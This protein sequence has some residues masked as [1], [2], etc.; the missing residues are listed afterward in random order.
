MNW[1]IGVDV[2]DRLSYKCFDSYRTVGDTINIHVLQW[3]S[4]LGNL[5]KLA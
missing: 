4:R 5:V 3:R 2:C 1:E